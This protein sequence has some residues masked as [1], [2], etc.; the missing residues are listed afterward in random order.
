MAP[1]KWMWR[2]ALGKATRSRFTSVVLAGPELHGPQMKEHGVSAP[3][4]KVI[5]GEGWRR[6]AAGRR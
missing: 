2:C 3:P 1:S 5:G 4:L 6:L